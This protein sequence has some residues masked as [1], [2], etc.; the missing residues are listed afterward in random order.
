[1][2][3]LL[4]KC[5]RRVRMSPCTLVCQSLNCNIFSAE[6]HEISILKL[7]IS[8]ELNALNKY[9]FFFNKQRSNNLSLNIM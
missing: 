4:D 6:Y 7:I 3:T 8:L 9:S 5:G 1:M 2:H